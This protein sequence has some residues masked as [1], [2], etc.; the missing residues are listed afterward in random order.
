MSLQVTISS[1]EVYFASPLYTWHADPFLKILFKINQCQ[2][3]SEAYEKNIT[4]F[5]I[6]QCIY[7]HFMFQIQ[8]IEA[9]II[10][11]GHNSILTNILR[12]SVPI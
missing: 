2:I 11:E 7:L 9:T 1:M 8:I 12:I 4:Q 10:C 6:S 3:T 5:H